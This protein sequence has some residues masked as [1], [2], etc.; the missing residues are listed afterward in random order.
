MI[1]VATPMDATTRHRPKG[2]CR[3]V[4]PMMAAST[5]LVS[6]T[7]DTSAIV[8]RVIAQIASP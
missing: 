8:A 1:P 2:S 4:A 3:N 7:A 6:R 5:T